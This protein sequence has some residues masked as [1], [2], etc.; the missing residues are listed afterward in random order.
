MTYEE[1]SIGYFL[2]GMSSAKGELAGK[3]E[4]SLRRGDAL[5]TPA[6]WSCQENSGTN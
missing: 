5:Y 3:L 6:L 1:I 2:I 4:L